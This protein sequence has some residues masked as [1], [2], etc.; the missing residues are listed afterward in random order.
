[1]VGG[2]PAVA[3]IDTHDA[4]PVSAGS[5]TVTATYMGLTDT[6]TLTV[7]P[8]VITSIQVT[9]ITPRLAPGTVQFFTAEAIFSDGTSRN[10]TGLATW[11]SSNPADLGVSDTPGSR[12]RSTAIT[13]GAVTVTASYLGVTGSTHVTITSAVI[14]SLSVTPAA[15][16]VPIG[17]RRQFTAQ[18]IFS[19]GSSRDVTGLSTWTSSSVGV[20]QVSDTPG[21]RG[22]T[23]ALAPGAAS[24]SAT[25]MGITGTG[26]ITVTPA[27]LTTVQVTPFLP[28]VAVGTTIQLMATGIFSDGTS[29][30][31]T[32]ACTWTSAA[33]AVAAVSDAAGTRGRVTALA[34][35]TA[36][37]SA[38]CRGVTGSGTVTVTGT[39]LQRVQV[40]PFLSALPVGYQ[41]Q[42]TATAV[43]TDGTTRNVTS[44]ATWTSW[45]P[46][47]RLQA[48]RQGARGW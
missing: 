10:V 48:T 31:L 19:D 47:T 26:A 5:A 14:T 16:A 4:T 28:A 2:N 6:T 29:M 3:V 25:Y 1:M 42:L 37:V 17:T 39:T 13:A 34:A 30:G 38:T 35:G 22:F 15:V 12:G 40:T 27:T 18:A 20:A 23:T 41:E 21:S 7:T 43:Y 9:P 45:Y 24:L 32:G 46:P 44:L 8:G 11:V 36:V 33:P